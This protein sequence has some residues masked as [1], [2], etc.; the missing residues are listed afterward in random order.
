[1]LKIGLT[2]GIGSGKTEVS[3]RFEAL[4]AP[5]IDTDVLAREVVE[6]GEPAL[7]RLVEAFGDEILQADGGLDR[8]RLRQ[9]AF[10]DP[11]AKQRLEAILH[12]AIRERLRVR[13]ERLE[14]EG[15]PYCVIVVPL[16]VETD[17]HEMVDRV[18]VVEAERE[19]RVQRV[20]SRAGM[21]KVDVERIMDT[22]ATAEQR[23]GVAHDVIHNDGTLNE[24]RAKVDRLHAKYLADSGMTG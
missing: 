8:H 11:A 10:A 14:Q 20:M 12:P 19:L 22:Q 5:V 7:G 6:P 3:G 17:F 15:A 18:L 2:G 4:G 23:L 21:E 9:R 13:L 16:L 1:M 24:L